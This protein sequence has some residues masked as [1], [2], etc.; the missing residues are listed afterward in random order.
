MKILLK[1]LLLILISISF[2]NAYSND[3]KKSET[4]FKLGVFDFKHLT[5][6]TAVNIKKV[7]DNNVE[8]PYLGEIT[9][10]YDLMA[11]ADIQESFS[12]EINKANR[13]EYAI[14]KIQQKQL[15]VMKKRSAWR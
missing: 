11:M 14:Y 8:L 13:E 2:T 10:I 6:M 15:Y 9:Q 12:D 5:D 7:T 1:F 3:S 4:Y